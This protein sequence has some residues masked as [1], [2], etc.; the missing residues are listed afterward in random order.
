VEF[1]QSSVKEALQ[2]ETIDAVAILGNS[3]S[4]F[5]LPPNPI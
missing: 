1:V 4:L 2:Q 3:P 5:R